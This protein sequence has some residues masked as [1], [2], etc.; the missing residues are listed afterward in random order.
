MLHRVLEHLVKKTGWSFSVIMGGPDPI[1][2]EEGNHITRLASFCGLHWD[3]HMLTN[4]TIMT[5]ST[6]EQISGDR[7][8]W[9]PTPSTILFL[10]KRM[11]NF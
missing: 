8:S 11:G 3:M 10:L 5:V 1:S 6:S 2:P 7:T 9:M 4:Y